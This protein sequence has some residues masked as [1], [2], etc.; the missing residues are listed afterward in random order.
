MRD[1]QQTEDD[2]LTVRP[3]EDK[4]DFGA[5]MTLVWGSPRMV[6]G[7][8]TYDVT[9]IDATGL[10]DKAG[11]LHAIA[12]WTMRGNIAYLCALHAVSPGKGHARRM[13]EEV[14][15]LA[16][17][18]GAKAM[19]AMVT[20]DNLP[21]F[22]FYQKNGFRFSNLFVGAVDAYRPTMPGMITHG[23]Q[24]IPVHDALELEIEL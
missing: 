15:L 10:Y 11:K 14:K 22:A 2:G 16:K 3:L 13:L 12:S 4:S 5:M 19:R 21:G 8:Y 24:G 9:Q 23:Y 18:K 7:M 6:V 17:A 20:N 1:E